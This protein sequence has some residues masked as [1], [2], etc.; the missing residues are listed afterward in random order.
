MTAAGRP[1]PRYGQFT[2]PH[3]RGEQ[4]RARPIVITHGWPGSVLEVLPLARRL[5]WPSRYGGD[6]ADAFHVVVLALPG[7]PLSG[8]AA[9][10]APDGVDQQAFPFIETQRVDA[11]PCPR[12]QLPD[13]Q[14]RFV[15]RHAAYDI[16]LT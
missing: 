4:D 2:G 5:A 12:G 3:L 6:P 16:A 10:I 11:Q 8:A 7:F 13:A 1:T 9:P 14:V 15:V